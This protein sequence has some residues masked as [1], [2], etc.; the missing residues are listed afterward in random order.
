LTAKYYAPPA[1]FFAAERV[2]KIALDKNDPKA[3]FVQ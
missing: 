1:K 2:L 3:L